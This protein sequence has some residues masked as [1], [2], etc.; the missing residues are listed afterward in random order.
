MQQ[1]QQMMPPQDMMAR[2]GKMYYRGGPDGPPYDLPGMADMDSSEYNS[3]NSYLTNLNTP[4]Y[5]DNQG[6]TSSILN[7]T[8]SNPNPIIPDNFG[9]IT[10]AEAIAQ[11]YQVPYQDEI[12][13]TQTPNF[14]IPITMEN[15]NSLKLPTYSTDNLQL[16]NNELR[17]WSG[18]EE[19][20][21]FETLD[22][23]DLPADFEL[24]N[25][26]SL[27]AKPLPTDNSL[28]GL[29]PMN[30]SLPNNNLDK[31]NTDTPW[32]EEPWWAKA[33]RPLQAIPGAIA[34]ITA[35]KNKKRRLDPAMM[36]AQTVNYEPERI[37]DREESRRALDSGLRTMR[38]SASNAG[39]LAGNTTSAVL[40]ANKGLAGRIAESV[41]R[42]ANTNAQLAQ[43]AGMTNT[44]AK[45][46]FKQ[47]NE[48][49][50]QNA[51]TQG[52]AGLQDMT[53]KLASTSMENRKQNLQE[54]I[55]KNRLG[56]R[57]Y[58][59]NINGQDVFVNA[60]GQIYDA[61]TGTLLSAG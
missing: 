51:Q 59:T 41:M 56:T 16:P 17:T 31:V 43:Q 60:E 54:W 30:L 3:I 29:V 10:E 33:A 26:P 5:V 15:L 36:A 49:M 35:M 23:K 9:P 38:G 48:G 12:D 11:G 42:E 44:A 32:F 52:I 50:F 14:N 58:K 61:K 6:N 22:K 4:N 34:A 46:Q 24:Q 19:E 1:E 18:P 7:R 21:R 20:R 25:L 47:I 2:G 27:K 37:I 39:M 57:S 45:N 55:A 8:L 28:P 40:N 53:S 13:Y